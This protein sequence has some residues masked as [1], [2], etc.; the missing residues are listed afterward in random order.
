MDVDLWPI[1]TSFLLHVCISSFLP[2]FLYLQKKIEFTSKVGTL[3]IPPNYA[4]AFLP[5]FCC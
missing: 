3:K 1:K 4:T 2:M 5:K